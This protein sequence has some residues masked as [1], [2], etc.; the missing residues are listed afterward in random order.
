MPNF[1]N[2]MAGGVNPWAAS[3]LDFL[4][5][6][7]YIDPNKQ[8]GVS[9]NPKAWGGAGDPLKAPSKEPAQPSP[10]GSDG[11]PIDLSQRVEYYK[12]KLG[13]DISADAQPYALNPQSAYK[14]PKTDFNEGLEN[15][16]KLSALPTNYEFKGTPSS[17]SLW[18]VALGNFLQQQNNIN[19]ANQDNKF[20]DWSDRAK[21]SRDK[22]DY[23]DKLQMDLS[24]KSVDPMEQ[25]KIA[26]ARINNRMGEMEADYFPTGKAL[27]QARTEFTMND[28]DRRYGLEVSKNNADMARTVALDK[29]NAEKEEYQRKQDEKEY[30]LKER[31]AKTAEYWVEESKKPKKQKAPGLT[32]DQQKKIADSYMDS[33]NNLG[34]V[35]SAKKGEIAKNI[36]QYRRAGLIPPAPAEFTEPEE[37]ARYNLKAEQNFADN[38]VKNDPE[39]KM[40]MQIVAAQ[41]AQAKTMGVN[42]QIPAQVVFETAFPKTEEKKALNPFSVAPSSKEGMFDYGKNRK[43][44]EPLEKVVAGTKMSASGAMRPVFDFLM[45]G[46]GE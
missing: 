14:L 15:M 26:G 1:N 11:S 13:K 35:A 22:T 6:G 42:T 12:Q 23:Q 28:A 29:R 38:A 46:W 20:K 24:A 43:K 39:V 4:Q 8:P 17:S 5:T 25:E 19:A 16:P 7:Q 27:E 18:A 44:A 41:E 3:I 31:A 10:T 21:R 32:V 33:V 37:I 30:G 34:K 9:L 36:L 2:Y 45:K 40:A